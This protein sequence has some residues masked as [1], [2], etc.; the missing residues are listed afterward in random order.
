M[1]C[2]TRAEPCA[3]AVTT[4]QTPVVTAGNASPVFGASHAERGK[5]RPFPRPS[6]APLRG[7]ARPASQRGA[8]AA[9][10]TP[11]AQSVRAP[12]HYG[13]MWGRVRLHA[14]RDKRGPSPHLALPFRARQAPERPRQAVKCRCRPAKAPGPPRPGPRPLLR[15]DPENTFWGRPGACCR[16]DPRCRRTPCGRN[17][18]GDAP[19]PAPVNRLPA[20]FAWAPVLP[21]TGGR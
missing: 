14:D 3:A 21:V 1:P 7:F 15:A 12:A 17:R 16:A 10:L 8:M 2:D 19:C 11:G 4:L 18:S 9:P 20:P 5:G 13:A 6:Q